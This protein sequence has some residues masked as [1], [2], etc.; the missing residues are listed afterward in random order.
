MDQA[1]IDRNLIQ[2]IQ[3]VYKWL[4]YHIETSRNDHRPEEEDEMKGYRGIDWIYLMEK[5]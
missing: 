5:W 1:W 2:E 3:E 4:F